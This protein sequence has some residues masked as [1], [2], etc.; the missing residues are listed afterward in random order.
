MRERSFRLE[1]LPALLERGV[2]LLSGPR[3]VR[4]GRRLARLVL[5]LRGS[6]AWPHLRRILLDYLWKPAACCREGGAHHHFIRYLD[7]EG[8]GDAFLDALLGGEDLDRA[9]S[10]AES[11]ARM[12]L[13]GVIR[14]ELLA[15][16]RD[17]AGVP[18]TLLVEAE[19]AP[20]PDCDLSCEGCYS[21][22]ER[23]V[24]D[25]AA[26]VGERRDPSERLA[27][28]V[29]EAATVGALA[30]HVVGKGEPLLDE[31]RALRLAAVIAARPHLL[32]TVATSGRHLT[33]RAA[34]ELAEL[35]NALL[36]VAVD[37]PAPLHDGRRGPGTHEGV[38]RALGILAEERAA[39]GFSCMVSEESALA[40][41]APEFVE[42]LAARGCLLGVYSRYFPL[43]PRFSERLSLRPE[44]VEKYSAAFGR[45]R[46]S[47]RIPLLDLDEVEARTG[48]R[49]RA[50]VSVYIDGTTGAV[51]PCIR[52]PF[53]PPEC[54]LDPERGVGLVEILAHP[55]FER[56][57]VARGSTP[58]GCGEDLGAELDQVARDLD[59]FGVRSDR[60]AGYRD[61]A[62]TASRPRS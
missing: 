25:A 43:S 15:R 60:L 7:Q 41:T 57:R 16:L 37:G 45:A 26:P 32:F 14:H 4:A 35:G 53:A 10:R 36:L 50:G 51:L 48:C 9:S 31:E 47:S 3:S 49:S 44:T 33:R 39:F 30:I 62:R 58:P 52:V 34:R 17:L 6:A 40:V 22:E 42:G 12:V 29:D 56:H 46:R 13:L 20:Y 2:R 5:G 38:L 24:R 19:V 59:A 28:A 55:F 18:R 23:T 21:E 11:F 8:V 1:R 61:R 54:R 27:A